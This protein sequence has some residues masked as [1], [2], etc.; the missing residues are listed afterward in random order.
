MYTNDAYLYFRVNLRDYEINET[1]D[2]FEERPSTSASIFLEPAT[3]STPA[4]STLMESRFNQF[5]PD[6]NIDSVTSLTKAAG[7]R[8]PPHHAFSHKMSTST[9]KPGPSINKENIEMPEKQCQAPKRLDRANLSSPS[10][11]NS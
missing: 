3:C 8:L 7:M 10:S 11:L 1:F 5:K 2:M 9:K 6:V 4:P